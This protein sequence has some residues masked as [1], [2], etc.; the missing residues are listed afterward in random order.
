MP[1]RRAPVLAYVLAVPVVL[2]VYVGAL[3]TKLWV[4]LR[5]AV[6]TFLGATVI[7]SVYADAALKRVPATPMRAAAVLALAVALVGSATAP[8][9]A[10]AGSDPVE[11]VI[12]AARSY[13]GTPYKLGAE[14]PDKFDCS[15]FLFHIFSETGQLPRIGGRRMIARAYM[16]HFIAR[17]MFTKD[18]DKAKRGDLIVWGMGEHIGLY[19]GDGKAISAILN[20]WGITLHGINWVPLRVDYF[21]QVDYSN[22]DGNGDPPPPDDPGDDDKPSDPPKDNDK[23]GDQTDPGG[24]DNSGRGDRPV[25]PGANEYGPPSSPEEPPPSDN[26]GNGDDDEP[27]KDEP[28]PADVS[29]G[30]ATGTLNLRVA[31]DPTA[32]IVGWVSRGTSFRILGSDKSP[33]GYLWYR[34]ETTAGYQ[35]WLFSHWVRVDER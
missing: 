17:G 29:K 22:G 30:T 32:R 6:A 11:D 27:G 15:G 28:A 9:P 8:T 4:A 23:D 13:L 26:P 10:Y 7:S 1:N 14:G 31:P 33:S 21:L 18:V 12:A 3:G 20:P 35:G 2:A 16:R 25:G 5:P 24:N 34:I 19:V